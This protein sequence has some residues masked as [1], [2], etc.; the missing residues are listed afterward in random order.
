MADENDNNF[1]GWFRLN[2]VGADTLLSGASFVTGSG[3]NGGVVEGVVDL[4]AAFG[5]VPSSIFI[6]A[7]PYLSADNTALIS[8]AQTPAGD[9]D[10]NIDAAEFVEVCIPGREVVQ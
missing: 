2:A 5:T 3:N 8:Q 9:G 6:A 1:A 10:G 4:A 7:A